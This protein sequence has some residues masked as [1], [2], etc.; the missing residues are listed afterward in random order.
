MKIAPPPETE[1][2]RT[3]GVRA[4]GRSARVVDAVLRA[5]VEELAR[6]GYAA[7]RVE[8]VAAR[9]GVNKTSIYRRWPKKV[10]L[11]M[12]A[13]E[14]ASP[15]PAMPD[16]GSLR[17]DL[18]ESARDMCVVAQSPLKRCLYR[19]LQADRD[20][21][22]LDAVIRRRRAEQVAAR[23]TLVARGIARG[24]LPA[25]TDPALFAELVMSPMMMRVMHAGEAVDDVFIYSVIDLMV[26]GA[27]GAR[28]ADPPAP[29][30]GS[31]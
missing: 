29:E 10:N 11:V 17:E 28:P 19:M 2:R 3:E 15:R 23:A 20:D 14:H 8:D 24:E 4:G 5:A 31:K 9:S 1:T 26:A 22:E 21:P 16:T 7:L 18:A 13:L 12:A 27:G 30:R 6:V 25:G